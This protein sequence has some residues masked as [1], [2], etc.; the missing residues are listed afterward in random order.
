MINEIEH[1]RKQMHDAFET[2]LSLTDVRMIHISQNLDKLLTKFHTTH[3]NESKSF[4]LK[5][6]NGRENVIMLGG[7]ASQNELK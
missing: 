3:K 1:L 2:G 4:H 7:D 6:I 5:S